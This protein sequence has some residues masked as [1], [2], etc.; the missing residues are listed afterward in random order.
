MPDVFLSY[1]RED[2]ATARLFAD[3]FQREG[4]SVWWDQ[5]LDPGEAFDEVTEKALHEAGAVVVLWSRKSVASRWVRAEATQANNGRKLCP[6]MIE[7]CKR[8]IMFELTQTAELSGWKGD[9]TDHTWQAFLAGVQRMVARDASRHAAPATVAGAGATT[10]LSRRR[11]FVAVAA[12][13]FAVLIAGVLLF[14]GRTTAPS[15]DASAPAPAQTAL[16]KPRIAILPFHN[17]SPDPDNAFFADGMHE[18]VLSALSNGAPGLEV[19][20]RT[21]MMQPCHLRSAW[22]RWTRRTTRG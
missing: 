22:C 16:A 15:V 9:A 18:E 5:S 10:V 21:T 13:G 11:R 14:H 1:S 12:G 7:P 17:L 20:S 6:V 2:L 8:P 4:L 19:I 3:G